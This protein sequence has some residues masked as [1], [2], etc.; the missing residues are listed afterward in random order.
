MH[1]LR[2]QTFSPKNISEYNSVLLSLLVIPEGKRYF[3]HPKIL[4]KVTGENGPLGMPVS[5]FYRKWRLQVSERW[6]SVS[7]RT[8]GS[9]QP[10]I[11]PTCHYLR[12]LLFSMVPRYKVTLIL[13]S[14]I[15][16]HTHAG[17]LPANESPLETGQ[18]LCG[19]YESYPSALFLAQIVLL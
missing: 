9:V 11:H 16:Q 6:K 8:R 3:M 19:T 17:Y 12:G 1:F 18:F 14:Y 13:F 2:T 7:L 15:A 5:I 4:L 10:P